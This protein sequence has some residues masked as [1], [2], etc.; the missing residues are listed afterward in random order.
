MR[1]ADL[2]EPTLSRLNR[3]F[4]LLASQIEQV[5]GKAGSFTFS[6]EMAFSDGISVREGASVLGGI[7]ASDLQVYA[8]NAAALAGGLKAGDFYRT[9]TGQVM[10]VY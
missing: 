3:L 4:Q 5:Q 6:S 2:K 1:P 8:N 10:V 7:N 9:A